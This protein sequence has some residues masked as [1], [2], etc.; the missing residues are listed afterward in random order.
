MHKL[1]VLLKT[2]EDFDDE[3]PHHYENLFAREKTS[4]PER[5]II[6]PSTDHIRILLDLAA[7]WESNYWLLYVLLNSWIGN[8]PGRYQ[9]PWPLD[10]EEVQKFLGE[11]GNYLAS[12]A[13]HHFWIGSTQQKALLVY[14]RHDVIYAYGPLDAYEAR[15]VQRGLRIGQVRFPAPHSHCF[16]AENNEFERKILFCWNWIQSPLKDGQD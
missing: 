9:S 5:L 7:A 11:F 6:A 2:D 12:D 13:R 1:G 16:N 4:G 14:D 3:V 8:E 10:Y 15:L